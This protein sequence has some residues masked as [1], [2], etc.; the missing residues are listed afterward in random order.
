MSCCILYADWIPVTWALFDDRISFCA[1]FFVHLDTCPERNTPKKVPTHKKPTRETDQV[2]V[3]L[4]S[5]NWTFYALFY[6]RSRTKIHF[7]YCLILHQT[8][9][10]KQFC[11]SNIS[12]KTFGEKNI[13]CVSPLGTYNHPSN[14][15]CFRFDMKFKQILEW[16]HHQ[17]APQ[18]LFKCW[19]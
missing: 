6:E 8:I 9:I 16:S 4:G 14:F 17:M 13:M 19:T 3:F 18:Y 2:W 10:Q 15:S 11:R 5:G 1:T 7:F 12:R